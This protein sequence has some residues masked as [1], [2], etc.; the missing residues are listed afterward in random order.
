MTAPMLVAAS[1]SSPSEPTMM[2]SAVTTPNWV[3]CMMISGVETFMS[4]RASLIQGASHA[5]RAVCV[6]EVMKS[7]IVCNMDWS[8]ACPPQ[9]CESGR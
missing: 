4:C 1:A 5:M 2:M 3:N 7:A 8:S 9:S 6:F